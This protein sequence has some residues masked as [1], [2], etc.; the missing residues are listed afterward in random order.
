MEIQPDCGIFLMTESAAVTPTPRG[1]SIGQASSRW[2]RLGRR[3]VQVSF[4]FFL[5]K[6][7]AWL[8]AGWLVW[9]VA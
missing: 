8:V 2:K 5:A 7:I 4:L 6:G 3:L 9:R 1:A